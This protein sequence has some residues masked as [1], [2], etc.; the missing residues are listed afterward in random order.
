M[1]R[2]YKISAIVFILMS[3]DYLVNK[4]I[5]MHISLLTFVK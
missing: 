4:F 2:V 1:Y 3:L 5:Y